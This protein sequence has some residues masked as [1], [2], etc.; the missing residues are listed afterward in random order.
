MKRTFALFI[1]VAFL[2]S[3][4]S[5][6]KIKLVSGKLGFLKSEKSIAI[7]YD[8]SQMGVGKFKSEQDYL[9]KKSDEYN[10][11]E[12]GKGDQW[13]QAWKNDRASRFQP[14]FEEL[15]NKNTEKLGPVF[16]GGASGTPVVMVV[17]TTYTEPGYNI[18]I[19][20]APAMINLEITFKQNGAE[21]AKITLKGAPGATFGGYDFDTGLRI[22]EAYAKAGKELGKFITKMAKK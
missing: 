22:G 11:K 13:K 3:G 19:S 21:A 18:A 7:E 6:Q 12:P 17:K 20:R 1:G 5:A 2:A 8:Y 9:D 10:K 16:G 4:V 15:L 14:K